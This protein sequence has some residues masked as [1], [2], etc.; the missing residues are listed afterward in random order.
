MDIQSL[1]YI[2]FQSLPTQLAQTGDFVFP[3]LLVCFIIAAIFFKKLRKSMF[4]LSSFALLCCL[5]TFAYADNQNIQ[6]QV[7]DNDYKVIDGQLNIDSEGTL[8][9]YKL[10]ILDGNFKDFKYQLKVNDQVLNNDKIELNKT[11]TLSISFDGFNYEKAKLLFNK[12]VAKIEF[13]ITLH[14]TDKQKAVTDIGRGYTQTTFEN[15]DATNYK[16]RCAELEKDGYSLYTS[17][18]LNE[19]LFSTYTKGEDFVYIYFTHDNNEIRMITAKN[20]P[21]PPKET[22][23]YNPSGEETASIMKIRVSKGDAECCVYRLI[24]GSFIILDSNCA[25]QSFS[26]VQFQDLYDCLKNQAPDPNHII[27]RMWYFSHCHGDHTYGLHDYCKNK[28]KFP[29]LDIQSFCYNFGETD[30]A[31]VHLKDNEEAYVRFKEDMQEFPNTKV[32]KAFAGQVFQFPGAKFEVLLTYSDM[33]PT[34]IGEESD[35]EEV[36]TEAAKRKAD[37]NLESALVKITSEAT[38]KSLLYTG[39]IGD[40]NINQVIKRYT[41][42]ILHS[43]LMT[44]PHHGHDQDRYRARNGNRTFYDMV[45]PTAIF[46]PA[47]VEHYNERNKQIKD[48]CYKRRGIISYI[49][50]EYIVNKCKDNCYCAGVQSYTLSM[51]SLKPVSINVQQL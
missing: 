25:I 41:P 33:C 4:V 2:E 50:T 29:N 43:E 19:N 47:T 8:N 46:F 3:I 14:T 45:N 1:T 15:S 26:G 32:Y 35:D 40:Y 34:V 13:D 17:N 23:S 9:S 51:S 42:D 36:K 37:G 27:I 30:E 5:T 21:L 28:E 10:D 31:Y 22:E 11:N 24:D 12:S 7:S 39:D 6:V 44:V 49:N 38:G 20:V 18:N 48:D 16:I